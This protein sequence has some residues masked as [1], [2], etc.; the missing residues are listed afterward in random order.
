MRADP[1]DYE[2]LDLRVHSFLRDVPLHD[3]WAIPLDGGGSDRSL[4]DVRAVFSTDGLGSANPLVRA[5]FRTRTA[6]GRV[7]GW[8][9]K[10]AS[11]SAASFLHRLTESDRQQSLVTPGTNEGPFRVLYVFAGESVAEI[12]NATVHAFS[13]FAL[14]AKPSGYLLYWAIY[15]Q[16]VGRITGFYMALI[17]PFRRLVVYPSIIRQIRTAWSREFGR[18]SAT[19]LE[20][21]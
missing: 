16:P 14:V 11:L 6:L 9:R 10:P 15:V 12:H 21:V 13:A 2:K 17:D 7:F 8:D 20:D 18:H 19:D 4:A 1:G 5:L 3:V